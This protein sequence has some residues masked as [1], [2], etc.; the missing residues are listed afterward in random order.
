MMQIY[1]RPRASAAAAASARAASA[2]AAAACA[3]VRGFHLLC[4]VWLYKGPV[5]RLS[6]A[7]NAAFVLLPSGRGG[8]SFHTHYLC[9]SEDRRW[10]TA[11]T[12]AEKTTRKARKVAV[13]LWKKMMH[14][15]ALK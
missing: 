13:K 15:N 12:V 8:A 1:I 14:F 11:V 7:N 2:R 10:K 6:F 3:S 5:L 4:A 9:W